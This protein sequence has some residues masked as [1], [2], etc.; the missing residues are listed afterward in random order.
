VWVHRGVE[1][2][3]P[4]APMI[5]EAILGQVYGGAAAPRA[6]AADP[7]ELPENLERFFSATAACCSPAEREVCC[8]PDTKEQWRGEGC[9]CR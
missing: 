6:S 1:Y 4:P 5:V 2:T 3:E 8:E 7:Y 9:G